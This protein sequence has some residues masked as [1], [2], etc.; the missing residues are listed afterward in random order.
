[1]VC[2]CPLLAWIP[3]WCVNISSSLLIV[4]SYLLVTRNTIMP[5]T[6]SI[7]W[8][9]FRFKG[10]LISLR[11][12]CPNMPRRISI[13]CLLL[14]LVSGRCMY[15]WYFLPSMLIDHQQYSGGRFLEKSL[16]HTVQLADADLVSIYSYLTN[17]YVP[18]SSLAATRLIDCVHGDVELSW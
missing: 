9:W 5:Q 17:H 8:I 12:V 6:H 3:S 4:Y 13:I 2:R 7:S 11:N 10:K 15:H 1:M 14:Q 18:Y 16:W